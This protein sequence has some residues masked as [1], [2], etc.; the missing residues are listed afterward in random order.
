M[1]FVAKPFSLRHKRVKVKVLIR[2]ERLELIT[3]RSWHELELI[4]ENW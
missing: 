2:E 3:F 4:S 1:E